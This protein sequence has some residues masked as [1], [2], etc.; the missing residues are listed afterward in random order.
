[1]PK[2]LEVA[3]RIARQVAERG[4]RLASSLTS[5]IRPHVS[6]ASGSILV[7]LTLFL[8]IGY[9]A[10]G[11]ANK[12][13][14]LIQGKGEWPSFLGVFV[15]STAGRDFYLLVLLLAGLTAIFVFLSGLNPRLSRRRTLPRRLF[16]LAGT[17]SL[18]LISDLFSALIAYDQPYSSLAV[19]LGLVSM[20][21]PGLFWPK[22]MFW[23][24][25]SAV[26]ISISLA[27]IAQA[28]NWPDR[29]VTKIGIEVLFLVAYFVVPLGL[30]WR[31]NISARGVVRAHW[32]PIRTGLVAFYS[33]AVVANLFYFNVARKEGVWGMV[34]CYFGIHLIALGYMRLAKEGEEWRAE[35]A[36]T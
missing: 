22:K 25:L 20:L 34:P 17:M 15:S 2:A 10:C 18:F 9:N 30:W 31:S 32:N 28:L 14:E 23:G 36:A 21:S 16:L 8:P 35:T 13:Y 26:A 6:L 12:G 27:F 7:L 19:A 29:G 5:R 3:R 4:E 11:G 24:W 33:P 1:M